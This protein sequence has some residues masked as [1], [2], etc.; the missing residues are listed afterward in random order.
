MK[1]MSLSKLG[2]I[3]LCSGA[4]LLTIPFTLQIALGGTPEEGTYIWQYFA[5]EILTGGA[6]SLLYPML[7]VMGIA[8][9]IFG[10][11]TL[12]GLLQEEQTDSLMSLGTVLT[13]VGSIGY[14][15]VWCLDY[16]IIWGD[17]ANAPNVMTMEMGFVFLFGI[18]NWSGIQC[19]ASALVGRAYVNTTLLKVVSVF[20]GL[21][22]VNHIYTVFS[23]DP[24]STASIMPFFIGMSLGQLV[25]LAFNVTLGMQMMKE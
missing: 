3:C 23:L 24:Y 16:N 22:V 9:L 17:S 7:S 21:H 14:M 25:L 15:I 1:S 5:N 10:I 2:G 8:F 12:N 20:A 6:L 11:Y 18:V 19:L 13:I 4:V